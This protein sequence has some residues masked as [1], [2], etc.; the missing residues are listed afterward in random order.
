M[1][2]IA[3]SVNFAAGGLASE[4][5]GRLFRAFAAYMDGIREGRELA[6]RYDALARMSQMELA[7]IGVARR[8]VTHLVAAGRHA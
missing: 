6:A 8:D 5:F 3:Q 1:T 2:T 4:R 7:R